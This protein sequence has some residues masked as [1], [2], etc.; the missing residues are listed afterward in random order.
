MHRRLFLSAAALAPGFASQHAPADSLVLITLSGG[1][2]QT[3]SLDPKHFTPFEPGMLPRNLL[4]TC[5]SIPTSAPGVRFAQGL[6]N[7]ASQMAHGCVVRSLIASGIGHVPAQRR[8]LRGVEL[9]TVPGP[10]FARQL[11]AVVPRLHASPALL[12]VRLPFIPFAGLDAHDRGGDRIADMKRAI[13]A[14]IAGLIANLHQ[15]GLLERTLV[16]VTSEFGRTVRNGTPIRSRE[17]YG[18]HE[19]FAGGHSALLFGAGVP[20]GVAY[21]RTADEHPMVAVENPVPVDRLDSTIRTI[22]GL[23]GASVKPVDGLLA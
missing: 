7:I 20:H 22:V 10:D 14:P 2:P 3:D 5:R 6:E 4:G 9:E 18:F 12:A 19:H 15:A 21:G 1:L 23:P 17:D 11:E 13:D 16:A 8:L